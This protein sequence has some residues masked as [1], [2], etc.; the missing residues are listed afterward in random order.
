MVKYPSLLIKIFLFF[1]YKIFLLPQNVEFFDDF[2]DSSLNGKW[3][4]VGPSQLSET[5]SCLNMI[6]DYADDGSGPVLSSITYHTNYA[7]SISAE[8]EWLGYAENDNTTFHMFLGSSSNGNHVAFGLYNTESYS[9]SGDNQIWLYIYNDGTLVRE[10]RIDYP[11]NHGVFKLIYDA[12]SK[13]ISAFYKKENTDDYITMPGSN[14]SHLNFNNSHW[15]TYICDNWLLGGP[16]QVSL[17]WS[18]II[19]E[20]GSGTELTDVVSINNDYFDIKVDELSGGIMELKMTDD[21]FNTNFII[22]K[23]GYSQYALDDSRWLGDMITNYCI[24][25]GEWLNAST[26]MSDDIREIS[27][28]DTV[29]T[30]FYPSG[31][32]NAE[33]GIRDFELTETYKLKGDEFL[34]ELKFVNSSDGE[35]NFGDIGLP[36]P[37][38]QYWTQN[39]TIVHEKRVF[40]HASTFMA[41]L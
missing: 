6:D 30:I 25:N 29:I 38:N 12:Q 5:G 40:R 22:G 34:W 4:V 35:L 23:E 8:V 41:Y 9:G 37:F 19:Y 32:S 26:S 21:I 10:Q 27:N 31:I 16:S 1:F 28:D 3:A 33:N 24:D 20:E 11:H 17:D 36:L 14:Y 39:Q 2:S 13:T 18:S 7:G 15:V